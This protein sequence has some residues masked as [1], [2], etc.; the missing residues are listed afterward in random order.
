MILKLRLNFRLFFGLFPKLESL[1]FADI[2]TAY[3]EVNIFNS[4]TIQ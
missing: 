1:I 2:L 3:L 4:K